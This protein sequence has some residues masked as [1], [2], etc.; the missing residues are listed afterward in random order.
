MLLR[1][2]VFAFLFCSSSYA[3]F[4]VINMQQ[5]QDESLVVKDLKSKMEKASKDFQ[6]DLAKS[7]AE[8]EKKLKDFNRI[9]STLSDEKARAKE[10]ELKEE[11]IA[12]ENELQK[13]ERNL[14][15]R[16]M[17]AFESIKLKIKDISKSIAEKKGIDIVLGDTFIIYYNQSSD[18][19]I[20]KDVIDELNKKMKKSSF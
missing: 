20:T 16:N 12:Y 9:A 7:K 17:M 5:I 11:L 19:D 1:Y 4:A 6:E 13:K 10:K 3:Q 8:V 15:E 18:I 2:I 14:Q